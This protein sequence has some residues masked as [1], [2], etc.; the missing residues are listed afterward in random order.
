MVQNPIQE[1]P[2]QPSDHSQQR[3]CSPGPEQIKM[4]PSIKVPVEMLIPVK[5]LALLNNVISKLFGSLVFTAP[6][7]TVPNMQTLANEYS[8]AIDLAVD[9]SRA[10]KIAR[11]TKGAEVQD[12]LRITAAYVRMVAN[13]D[14]DLL[15][16]T[17]FPLAKERKPVVIGIP[18]LTEARMTGKP[19]DVLLRFTGVHG[20]RAYNVYVTEQ[21]PA[22]ATPN[23]TL[24]GVTSKV[25]FLADNLEP[26]KAYWFCVSA[27]GSLGEGVKS[28]PIIARAA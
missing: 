2:L 6:P 19:G 25:S 27:I 11:D 1:A 3:R 7:V 5:L 15:S 22:S 21:D 16:V 13:G 8:A 4:K 14:P 24:V 23:W 20:R 26:Y 28:D 17:G 12:T 9:G 10:S 18:L